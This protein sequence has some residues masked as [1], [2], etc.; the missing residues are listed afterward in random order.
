VCDRVSYGKDAVLNLAA[1]AFGIEY[2]QTRNGEML[3]YNLLCTLNMIEAARKMNVGRLLIVSS[4]CAYPD[5][6]PIPTP[7]LD[8][9][10]GTPE[11][12]NEGYGWAKRIQELAGSYYA[13]D[14]DAKITIARLFNIYGANYRWGGEEKAHVIPTLIKRVMG[15]EDPLIVW[16]SGKQRRNFLHANDA[17]RLILLVMELNT[18]AT[19]VNIGYEDEVS[20]AELVDMICEVSGRAPKVIFD[21]SK[22]E[23]RFRKSAD[24]TRLRHMTGHYRPQVSLREGIEEMIDWYKKTFVHREHHSLDFTRR[25]SK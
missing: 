2:S 17:A 18:M 4:S 9:F 21:A 19:P 3:V 13:H 6:A 15:G 12:A 24:A 14:Y 20:I 25:N 1:R 23:G 22:P 5:D 10:T 11:R 8:V 7:E 16:G